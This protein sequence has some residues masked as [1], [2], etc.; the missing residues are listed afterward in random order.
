AVRL[1]CSAPGVRL[2]NGHGDCG[3]PRRSSCFVAEAGLGLCGRGIAQ[4]FWLRWGSGFVA[5]V[6]LGLSG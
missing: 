2:R 6:L 3:G 5:E 4:A 1:E